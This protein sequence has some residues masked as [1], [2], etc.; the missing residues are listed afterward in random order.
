MHI[1]KKYLTFPLDTR[2]HNILSKLNWFLKHILIA[3]RLELAGDCLDVPSS[4][5]HTVSSKPHLARTV[6][7]QTEKS[8]HKRHKIH[9]L[10]FHDP[11]PLWTLDSSS[12]MLFFLVDC[13]LAVRS[14]S[15]IERLLVSL[16]WGK[17][18]SSC[19]REFVHLPSG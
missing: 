12:S 9:F 17:P 5:V 14:T 1:L 11:M 13:Q 10:D 4:H 19:W 3:V 15:T 6:C 18:M 8:A 7:A 2:L 16:K